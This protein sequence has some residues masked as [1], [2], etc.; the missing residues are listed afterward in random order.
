MHG[1]P[2][3]ILFVCS[4][5]QW[6]SPTAERIYRKDD[7]FNVRS[8]GVS[9]SARKRVPDRDITWADVI[10]AMDSSHA[11]RLRPMIRR[12]LSQVTLHTLDVPDL[13]QFMDP[14]LVNLLRDRIEGVFT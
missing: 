10:I 2:I 4:R 14:E 1:N 13:Y 6:R 3:N 7:R 11:D 5:N 12:T 9:A 8:A